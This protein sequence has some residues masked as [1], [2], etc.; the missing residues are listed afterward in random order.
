VGWGDVGW[1]GVG[2]CW[3]VGCVVQWVVKGVLVGGVCGVVWGGVGWGGGVDHHMGAP[4]CMRALVYH[5]STNIYQSTAVYNNLQQ[6]T[7]V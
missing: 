3:L 1:C 7:T 6:S 2:W 4:T 5:H